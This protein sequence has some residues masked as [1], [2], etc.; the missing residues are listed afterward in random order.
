MEFSFKN[1]KARQAFSFHLLGEGK[2]AVVRLDEIHRHRG[3]LR[4][5][6]M[7]PTAAGRLFGQARR[8]ISFEN[9]KNCQGDALRGLVERLTDKISVRRDAGL[10]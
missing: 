7:R 2:N 5:G 8:F 6:V 4:S 3:Q 10:A 9:K 1:S